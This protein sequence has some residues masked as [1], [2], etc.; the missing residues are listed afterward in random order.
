LQQQ[1]KVKVEKEEQM[2]LEDEEDLFTY[3]REDAYNMVQTYSN[4]LFSRKLCHVV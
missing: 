1:Q 3:T 2:I 4:V